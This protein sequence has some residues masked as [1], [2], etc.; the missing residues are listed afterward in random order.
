[1]HHRYAMV[2]PGHRLDGSRRVV[3][4][5]VDLPRPTATEWRR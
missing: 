4:D 5:R 3:L 2:D 1:M